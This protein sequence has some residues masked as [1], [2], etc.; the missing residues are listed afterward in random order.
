MNP[1]IDGTTPRTMEEA[2]GR[3]AR[4]HIERPS[5]SRQFAERLAVLAGKA[6]L[7]FIGGMAFAGFMLVLASA[8]EGML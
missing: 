5:K 1:Y 8:A 3:R 7:L 4:L 6:A 2:F